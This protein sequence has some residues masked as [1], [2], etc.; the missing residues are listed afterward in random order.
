MLI[1]QKNQTFYLPINKVLLL[2]RSFS[3][4][5]H[6]KKRTKPDETQVNIVLNLA[7][8]ITRGLEQV[9]NNLLLHLFT[10]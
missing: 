2:L 4:M 8:W 1:Q 6:L 5:R 3:V 9:E 7:K 10:S